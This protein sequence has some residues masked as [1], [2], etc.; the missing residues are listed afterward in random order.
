MRRHAT[1]INQSMRL[2]IISV[3][4]ASSNAFTSINT[5][6]TSTRCHS[7]LFFRDDDYQIDLPIKRPDFKQRMKNIVKKQNRT[8][9]R[10]DNMRTA[11]TLQEYANV[12]EEA[13]RMDRLVVVNFHATWCKVRCGVAIIILSS[14]LYLPSFT[15]Y[16]LFFSMST[17]MSLPSS[18][19]PQNGHQKPQHHLFRRTCIRI[20]FKSTEGFGNR[21]CTILSYLSS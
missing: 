5:S 3:L 19:I 20:Q 15:Q 7:T 17:E 21:E 1:P 8:A 13:R 10:P 16:V 2:M 14:C 11:D 4:I 9:W 12:I 6:T 18:R